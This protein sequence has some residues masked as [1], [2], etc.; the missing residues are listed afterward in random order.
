MCGPW[1][2]DRATSTREGEISK[3]GIFTSCI[4]ILTYLLYLVPGP[5]TTI[6]CLKAA[7]K[8]N[9]KHNIQFKKRILSKNNNKTIK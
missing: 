9:I 6:G 7:Y 3:T 4:Y 5:L 2:Y 8:I 1:L